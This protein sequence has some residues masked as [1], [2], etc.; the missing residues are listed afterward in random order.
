MEES[1]HEVE[2][3]KTMVFL[4]LLAGM[5]LALGLEEKIHAKKSLITGTF[6]VVCVLL[7]DIFHLLPIGPVI[8]VFHEELHI[9]V[10]IT[11]GKSSAVEERWIEIP[12]AEGVRLGKPKQAALITGKGCVAVADPRLIGRGADVYRVP[13]W[14]T[15]LE[16]LGAELLCECEQ[17]DG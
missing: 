9:P 12:G 11:G 1:I 16:E 15:H 14:V 2:M 5:V 8:N 6:A 10:Y 3:W 4:G 13:L 7:A 17:A